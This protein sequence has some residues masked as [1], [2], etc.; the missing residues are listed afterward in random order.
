MSA[1]VVAT[2][3]CFSRNWKILSL[4]SSGVP[5]G[6]RQS[7]NVTR[8]RSGVSEFYESFKS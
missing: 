6:H 4:P 7:Q 2:P 1:W 8:Y 5:Y 3:I